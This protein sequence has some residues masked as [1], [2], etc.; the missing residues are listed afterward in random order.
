M[1]DEQAWEVI[2]DSC[3]RLTASPAFLAAVRD[4]RA[5]RLSACPGINAG[6]PR[7]YQELQAAA[8]RRV[9]HSGITLRDLAG[10]YPIYRLNED[11]DPIKQQE[12]VAA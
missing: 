3:G 8:R 12:A 1:G 11:G 4:A 9:W 10:R 6:D 7:S 2:C 5:L